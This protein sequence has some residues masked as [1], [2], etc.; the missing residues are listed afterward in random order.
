[1]IYEKL[2]QIL[3]KK[4]DELLKCMKF[5]RAKFDNLENKLV[6][7]KQRQDDLDKEVKECARLQQVSTLKQNISA[8]EG[9]L[10]ELKQK[11]TY[12]L[13]EKKLTANAQSANT[14]PGGK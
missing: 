10:A 9:E 2:W 13:V 8:I 7:L 11:N 14:W 3:K 1:M 12:V 6:K 5:L 4:K